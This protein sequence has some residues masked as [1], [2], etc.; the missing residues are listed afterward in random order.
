MGTQAVH[1]NLQVQ[2]S[3]RQIMAIALPISLAILV[4]QLNYIT[5]NI[6]LGR[7]SEQALAAA[8]IT[9][10][11]YLIFAAIGFGLN[12]GLQALI[13]RR[14][15]ENKPDAIGKLFIHG[16]GI[17]MFIA[18]L[19]IIITY[20]VSPWVLQFSIHDPAL[21]QQSISFLKIRIWGLPF[22]YIYQMRNA[23][24]VGTN[25]SKYLVAGTL[26]EAISNIFFDYSLIFGHFGFPAMGFNGAAV[27]S[28]I[29]EFL[30]M[31]VVFA[32]IHYKGI[33]KRFSLFSNFAYEPA[34]AG[35]ILRQSGPLIFQNAISIISWEFFYILI[36]HHGERDLSISNAMRNIFGLFGMFS[37]ALAATCSSMVSNIIGQGLQHRVME[38]IGKI[39]KVS[40][41]IALLVCLLLNLF[42][43]LYLSVYG[44]NTDWVNHAIPVLRIVSSALVIMSFSTVCVN[45][46]T[47]TG[48]TRVSFFIELVTILRYCCFVWT[49]LER[50]QLSV[51]IGWTSEW[52]YWG[53]MFTMSIIYLRSGRWKGKVI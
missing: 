37:W 53:A 41:G 3:Y 13:S 51:A 47:G 9:G 49:V 1:N 29:A 50:L 38:L 6:F 14:A 25:Q 27:A 20:T 8:A 33:G 24:L 39:V 46:V 36:E 5:N 52:L 18:L 15:G 32:V 30:G 34:V 23:L 19:G 45:A 16:V 21:L 10:V 48:N 22:L 2:I 40:T 43:Y 26:A 44:Q 42:P 17:S 11:Y 7:L 12:N 4:P 35:A 28:I 31:A